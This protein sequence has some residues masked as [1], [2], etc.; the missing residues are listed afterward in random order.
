MVIGGMK[1]RGS[2]LLI[3]VLGGIL[4]YMRWFVLQK[5][6]HL[7]E[8][9]NNGKVVLGLYQASEATPCLEMVCFPGCGSFWSLWRIFF[10]FGVGIIIGFAPSGLSPGGGASSLTFNISW[11][12]WR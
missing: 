11:I 8:F 9:V 10:D 3:L 2:Q 4:K 6:R 5:L 7:L 12:W 1:R